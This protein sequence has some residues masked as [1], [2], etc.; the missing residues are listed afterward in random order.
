MTRSNNH[1]VA[2]KLMKRPQ[3]V[4][5]EKLVEELGLESDKQARGI[6]DRLR[7][8]VGRQKDGTYDSSVGLRRIKNVG[9]HTFKADKRL[10][11]HSS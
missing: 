10:N 3:G 4:T 11:L 5:V 8:K 7:F 6:V 1:A 9:S 2:L